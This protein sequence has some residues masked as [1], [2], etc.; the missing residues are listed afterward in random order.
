MSISSL[1]KVDPRDRRVLDPVPVKSSPAG[2]AVADGTAW[3]TA[4]APASS[5][6]GGTLRVLFALDPV[7]PVD[8]LDPNG[9]N[10]FTALVSPL[11]Y[12]GLVAYRRVGGPSGSTLVGALDTSAPAPIDGGLTY[13]FT[14][15]PGLR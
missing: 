13:V 14:L 11:A 6:R 3:V 12:D 7:I 5:H 10:P 8:W 4:G 1:T 9:W 15:R 2:V